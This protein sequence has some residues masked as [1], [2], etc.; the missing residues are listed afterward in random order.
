[1]EHMVKEIN[2]INIQ[3]DVKV[4]NPNNRIEK[5]LMVTYSFQQ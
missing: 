5:Y 4:S 1:M 3:F 2:N